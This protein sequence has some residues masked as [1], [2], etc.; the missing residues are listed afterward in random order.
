MSS[1]SRSQSA[2]RL[3]RRAALREA[4]HLVGLLV[5]AGAAYGLLVLLPSRI[6]TDELRRHRDGLAAEV[7]GLE[8]RVQDLDQ[9][10]RGLYDDPWVVERTLRS[11]LGYLRTGERVF[12]ATSR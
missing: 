2:R 7:Q 4:A 8:Q 5:A 6:K 1:P 12:R 9:E 11:R 3:R 10:T